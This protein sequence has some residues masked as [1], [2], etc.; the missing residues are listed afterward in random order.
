MVI[1]FFCHLRLV[2][3]R[4]IPSNLDK[5]GITAALPAIVLPATSAMSLG[6]GKAALPS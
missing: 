6:T 1:L 3:Y 5:Y 2:V 4:R